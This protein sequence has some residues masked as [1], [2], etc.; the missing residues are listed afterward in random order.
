[1]TTE[2]TRKQKRANIRL[3]LILG[4]LAVGFFFMGLFLSNPGG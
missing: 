4:V 1:M 2:Q 3:A